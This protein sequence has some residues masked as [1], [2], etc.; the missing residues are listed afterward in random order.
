MHFNPGLLYVKFVV[1]KVTLEQIVLQISLVIPSYLPSHHCPIVIYN[2]PSEV[3][4]S[5]NQGAH[6]H[7]FGF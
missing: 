3:C 5:P 4:I 2:R 7:I 1:C 6:F